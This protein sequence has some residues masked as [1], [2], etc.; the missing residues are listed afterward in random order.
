MNEFFQ[1]M[2]LLF[3]QIRTYR[4]VDI[5]KSLPFQSGASSTRWV[6]LATCAVISWGW[7]L[8]VVSFCILLF[9]PRVDA[10][11]VGTVATLIVSLGGLVVGFSTRSQNLKHTL[12]AQ[13]QV[14]NNTQTEVNK[15]G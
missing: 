12:Q 10:V 15:N 1:N 8:I 5:L 11:I 7:L 6:Y 9:R 4:W 13:T 3:E 2:K 14:N